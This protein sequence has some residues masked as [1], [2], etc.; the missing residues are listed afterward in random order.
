[1]KTYCLI[2]DDDNQEQYFENNVRKILKI[3]QID[4]IP[5]FINPTER[6]YLKTDNSGFDIELIEKD[7]LEKI[8]DNNCSIVLSDYQITT[9]NVN[10]TGLD[11][12]TFLGEKKQNLYKILYSG[13]QI[14]NAVG[15]IIK[16]LSETM[17]STQEIIGDDK[18]EHVIDLLNKKSNVD[19]IVQGKGYAE[20]VIKYFRSSPIILQQQL[21]YQLKVEYPDM[22]FKSC[23]PVFKGANLKEIGEHIENK[24]YQGCDFQQSLIEQV[25]AYLIDVNKD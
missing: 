6:K 1:M 20:K 19:D 11:I 13:A 15:K 17:S 7:C 9:G 25:V 8:K 24:T 4:L 21:L 16:T 12:L 2:I 23:Y 10:F 22:K 14:K 18:I 5:I 3:D